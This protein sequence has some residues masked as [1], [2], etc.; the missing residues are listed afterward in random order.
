MKDKFG[1][2]VT[3]KEFGSRWKKGME[4]ITPIQQ[5]ITQLWFTWIVV[6]GIV[7]GMV[8]CLF[9]IKTLLWLFIVLLGALGNTLVQLLGL[10]QKK[11]I[12]E[13]Y[14][15]KFKEEVLT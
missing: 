1:N 9:A 14:S 6:I 7:F 2:E 15:V 8:V 3:W 10:W 4:G 13:V 11:R 5:T 12:L